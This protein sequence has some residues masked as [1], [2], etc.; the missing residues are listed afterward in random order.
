MEK[1]ESILRAED[2]ARDT[3]AAAR[4][5]AQRIRGEAKVAAAER[6]SAIEA[7]ARARVEVQR[8]SALQQAEAEAER[9]TLEAAARQEAEFTS[10]VG[11]VDGA[12][13]SIL[14]ELV[15]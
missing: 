1:L 12:V 4:E 5:E 6:R 10:A 13:A 7:E 8:A 11:R 3:V 2:K 15:D 9:I 14:P